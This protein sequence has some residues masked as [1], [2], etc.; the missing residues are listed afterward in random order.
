[1]AELS[2]EGRRL[3]ADVAARHGVSLETTTAL[4]AAVA[5]GQGWQ[6]QFDLPE[7]GGMGQWSRGG[8][9]MIGDMF[10]TALKARVDALCA[11]L[12]DLVLA[13]P[14]APVAASF[15]SQSQGGAGPVVSGGLFVARQDAGWP[16]ELGAPSAVGTQDG[17]RYAV[18]PG[19]RRLAVETGGRTTVY[20]TGAHQI[21]GASQQQGGVGT[22]TFSSQFGTVRLADLPVVSGAA[23]PEPAGFAEPAAAAAPLAPGPSAPA[24]TP[25]ADARTAGR[26][27]V[28]ETA[29]DATW[30]ARPA[31]AEPTVAP[32]ASPPT[33]VADDPIGL[34]ERL[35][36]LRDKGVLT[37]AEFAAKKAELLARL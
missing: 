23:A 17:M 36:G 5:A 29:L 10:N 8:M 11:E 3:L 32:V 26:P 19:A 7:L 37:E 6:A 4:A 28:A 33:T 27:V 16:A 31:V 35:A 15:Q 21:G 18:F 30:P 14:S 22:L 24:E 13:L 9:T 25:L 1:M 2:A 34:I 12:S 20:D